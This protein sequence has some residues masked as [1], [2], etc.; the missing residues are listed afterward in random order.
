MPVRTYLTEKPDVAK[1]VASY[2][3]IESR[4][5]GAYRLKNGDYVT[6]NI[7]HLIHIGNPDDYLTDAQQQLRG[8]DQLPIM[9]GEF[10]TFPDRSKMD[11]IKV[12]V[13]LL[14]EAD[15]IVNAGDIDR[16][17]QLIADE[18]IEYAGFDPAGRNKPVERV[19]ITALDDESLRRALTA[20][21]R[22]SN[23]EPRFVN[24]RLAGVARQQWDWLV[25][26]NGS[27]AVRAVLALLGIRPKQAL[28]LGRV[29]TPTLALVVHR[30]LEILNFKSVAYFVPKIRRPDGTVLTWAG[31]VEGADEAGIDAEGRI[32]DR[33]VAEAIVAKIM[34]SGVKGVVTD[35]QEQKKEQAPPLPYNLAKLQTEMSAR[36]GF[37]AKKTLDVTQALYENKKMVSYV[38]TDCQ[39]LPKSMH[40]EATEKL[41]GISRMYTKLANG[42]D[43]KI[44]YACWDD[45]KVTAHHAIIP[46]GVTVP[47]M[48][49]DEQ[50]V[51]D[52]IARRYIAQFYPKHQYLSTKLEA[53]YGQD[54][55]KST[56]RKTI[57]DGWKVVDQQAD[58]DAKEADAMEDRVQA[59][60]KMK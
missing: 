27:R 25:G 24:S 57:V 18:I 50:K 38:G 54:V 9:P 20:D 39:Y 52:A 5:P 21:A 31:R 42:A 41:G 23:G 8:F 59:R 37:S 11:Q 49:Q 53:E 28:S 56:S 47:G 14:K 55:F 2:L 7:G 46:T 44:Q 6:N 32:I 33:R 15:I 26:M 58:E 43:P 35:F 60:M 3:G 19:L 29:Q 16:E 45:S 48:S 4:L 30:E 22:L 51:F 40:A 17:G 36:H 1:H 12:V 10:K 34:Q 13:K